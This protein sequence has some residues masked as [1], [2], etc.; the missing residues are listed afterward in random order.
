MIKKRLRETDTFVTQELSLVAALIAWD[1]PLISI[2][3]SDFKKV[4]F[5]FPN[6]PEL[7]K[8]IQ[9]FWSDTG[10]VTPKKYFYALREAKSRI[11]GE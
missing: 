7:H 4:I 10:T 9:T 11:Y 1:F 3:K 2:D 6:T 8:A 5:V